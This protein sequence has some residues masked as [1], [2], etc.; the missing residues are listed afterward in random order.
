MPIKDAGLLRLQAAP[1][2]TQTI[3][4]RQGERI[5]SVV[6]SDPSL[7]FVNVAGTG[8]SL[9][10]RAASP[11]ALG[12]MSVRTNLRSYEFEL[13]AGPARTAPA[14]VRLTR[15]QEYPPAADADRYRRDLIVQLKRK[16]GKRLIQRIWRPD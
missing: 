5:A 2:V 15:P 14:V 12:V 7:F 16:N 13:M 8:D 9:A 11:S 10:L 4:F 6:L 1:D 3:L